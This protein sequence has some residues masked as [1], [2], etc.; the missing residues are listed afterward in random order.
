MSS[1]VAIIIS[2]YNGLSYKYKGKSI[3]F[4]VLN[5]LIKNTSYKNYKV[6]VAD[7]YSPDNSIAY[8]KSKFPRVRIVKNSENGG[9]S[10][11]NNN[12][13]KYAIKKYDPDYFLLLNNDI[14]I[15]QKDWLSEMVEAA[16]SDRKV[17]MVG[18]KLIY[19]SRYI[20]HTGMII[21]KYLTMNRGRGEHDRKGA[22][23]KIEKMQGIT[24]AVVL[25]K[26]RVIQKVG[27]LDENF[28]MGYED[29]DYNI[30]TRNEGFE[31]IYNGKVKLVHLEGFSSTN[32]SNEEQEMKI[33]YY[34]LR[35]YV[36]F[37]YKYLN[38]YQRIVGIFIGVV[39]ECF[40]TIEG[41]NRKRGIFNLRIKNKAFIRIKLALKSLDTGRRL[42]K[43][44]TSYKIR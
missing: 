7:D 29:V 39:L 1:K 8:I 28:F 23:E 19:P 22:Y 32:T 34:G 26:K 24:F 15:T 42:Y 31:I 43:K 16:E 2:N 10:K 38:F 25:I 3:I 40:L 12:A 14:I 41:P 30:R 9:Y 13:I 11:N 35:N 36:Y 27:L 18:C 20:Q 33:F 6:I 37:S 21:K 4:L 44:S 5:S 17:G